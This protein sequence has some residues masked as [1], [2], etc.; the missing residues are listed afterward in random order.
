MPGMDNDPLYG[1]N[2]HGV[3]ASMCGSHLCRHWRPCAAAH[4]TAARNA[5]R[6]PGSDASR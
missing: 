3:L 4:L 1:V 5:C 6:R 2:N